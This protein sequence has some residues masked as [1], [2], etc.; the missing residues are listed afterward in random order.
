M[1]RTIVIL[2]LLVGVVVI[3]VVGRGQ[4]G[5][6]TEKSTGGTEVNITQASGQEF[7]G[8]ISD[9]ATFVVDVHTPEQTHLPGTDVFIPYTDLEARRD[10][11]P[12]DTATAIAVYC[13]SGAMSQTASETLQRLGYQRIYN[14]TGGVEALKDVYSVVAITPS[15]QNLGTVIY[16]DK[17]RT[18]FSLTNFTSQPVRVTRLSTSC[19]CTQAE[20]AE[21]V[22]EAYT[23][24]PIQVSFDPAVHKDDTDLG[25][26]RR[27]I[28]LETDVAEFNKLSAEITARV[29][30]ED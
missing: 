16:G 24:V 29:I 11:L 20:I 25:E 22:V 7:V 19:G 9:P 17:A 3:G 15:E 2:A 8:L 1:R 5:R 4:R 26:V 12:T 21:K 13:R 23:S 14:L 30:K 18:E 10:E 27:T 6:E 28:Y